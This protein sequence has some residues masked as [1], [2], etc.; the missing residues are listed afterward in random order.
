MRLYNGYCKGNVSETRE[1]S[2]LSWVHD[3]VIESGFLCS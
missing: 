2:Q 3:Y 1:S